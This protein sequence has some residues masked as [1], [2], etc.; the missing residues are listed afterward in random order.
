LG[1]LP[2]DGWQPGQVVETSFV[3]R[4]PAGLPPGDYRLVTGF[5]DAETG[6]GL[7]LASGEDQVTLWEGNVSSHD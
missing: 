4:P 7:A 6:V 1:A 3:L 5:Y 2:T